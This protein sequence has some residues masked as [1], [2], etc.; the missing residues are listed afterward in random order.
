MSTELRKHI[1]AK[2]DEV[3]DALG[4]N[5]EQMMDLIE[6]IESIQSK[7]AEISGYDRSQALRLV[8]TLTGNV[9]LFNELLDLYRETY[10][11]E[12]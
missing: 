3:E 11:L 5:K 8:S 1:E 10:D 7:R 2:M 6:A 9:I 12:K 4:L